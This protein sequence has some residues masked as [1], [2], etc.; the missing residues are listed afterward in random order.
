MKKL[1]LSVTIVLT[2]IVCIAQI[3]VTNPLCEKRYNP[4]GLDITQSELSWQLVSSDRNTM[5]TACEIRIAV[6]K[7]DVIK[8]RTLIWNSG[9]I[10][11]DQ[12]LQVAYAGGKLQ[13]PKKQYWQ[14]RV[15]DNYGK[16]SEWSYSV[17]YL[18]V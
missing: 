2:C 10:A 12:S 4:I 14:V 15:R 17:T 3:A 6:N 16:V 8:G 9:K 18:L 1:F 7:A 11:S 13:S 5:Q